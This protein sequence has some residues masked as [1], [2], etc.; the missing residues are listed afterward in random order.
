MLIHIYRGILRSCAACAMLLVASA[1][2]E[3]ADFEDLDTELPVAFNATPNVMM[4]R[5]VD[6][7]WWRQLNDPM[8]NRLVQTVYAENLTLRIASLRVE[9]AESLRGTAASAI[10]VSGSLASSVQRD[11]D[12]RTTQTGTTVNGGLNW[13]FDP[14]GRRAA[15]QDIANNRV[16]LAKTELAI[17]RQFVVENLLNAYVDLRFQQARHADLQ[18]EI[19]RLRDTISQQQLVA[20][21]GD[22]TEIELLNA[23]A[24]LAARQTEFPALEAQIAISLNQISILAGTA[25]G[26]QDIDLSERRPQPLPPAISQAGLPTDLLRNRPDLYFLE[27]KYYEAVLNVT[28]ARADLY[29]QLSL[30]GTLA[31]DTIGADGRI[32]TFGPRLQLP[33]FPISAA[34]GRVSAAEIRVQITY[35]EWV[36]AVLIAISEAEAALLTLEGNA[37]AL[38]SADLNVALNRRS[39]ELTGSVLQLGGA[40]LEDVTI[41]EGRLGQAEATQSKLRQDYARSFIDL[42]VQLGS[43][44]VL[45]RT[46]DRHLNIDTLS[47]STFERM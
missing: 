44:E 32:A 3:V 16:I 4:P 27:R 37:K 7:V 40:T 42:Q 13:L 45:G 22:V 10:S 6:V 2:V 36:E 24:Q 19:D 31:L 20:K 9:E 8:V 47:L 14:F 15:L 21:T 43:G 26:T 29:P 12:A 33:A 1:C 25:P 30:G 39:L 28:Q 41:A 38:R 23:R 5:Q 46:G 18:T 17:A 11:F 35:D 34:Q